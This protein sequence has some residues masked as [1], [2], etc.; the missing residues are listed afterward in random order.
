MQ[1]NMPQISNHN[2]E[3]TD[4]DIK[5]AE[6]ILLKESHFF[7]DE[8]KD[9]IKNLDTID[10]QAVPWSWKT[11]ALLAKLL[12]L[13]RK[14][15][16]SDWSGILVLSHTNTAVDEIKER[17][18]KYAPKLFE[19]P[20]F[21]W[22]IQEFVN[23]FLAKPYFS[24]K[25]KKK[26]EFIDTE[27]YNN[28]IDKEIWFSIRWFTKQQKKNA[29]YFLNWMN[30]LYSINFWI[31]N[32]KIILIDNKN[33]EE[34]VIKK[35]RSDS[36]SVAEKKKVYE[37]ILKFKIKLLEYWYTNFDDAYFLWERYISK[38]P[39]IKK[40]LQKRF[41]Y[42]FVD[43]MQ[44][45][46]KH[47][48]D[49]LED[50]F[51][52][53]WNSESF[54]QRIWDENQAIYDWIVKIQS[55]WKWRDEITWNSNN[56]LKILW[57]HRF[58]QKIANVVK[59]FWL[60]NNDL[61]W[62]RQILNDNW[63]D[64]SKKPILI[65]YDDR[66]L[67]N[68]DSEKKDNLILKEFANI[69]DECKNDWYFKW[70]EK[71]VSK[72]IIWNAKPQEDRSW[73]NKFEL[74]KCRAKHYFFDYSVEWNKSK[75]KTWFKSDKDY[76]H[77][78]D[79]EK[80]PLKSKYNN[81]INLFLNILRNNDVKNENDK[82]F[83]KTSLLK[84]LKEKDEKKYIEFKTKLFEWSNELNN[85]NIDEIAEKLD[86]YFPEIVEIL[87]WTINI[88]FQIK[89]S[90]PTEWLNFSNEEE[91]KKLNTYINE[92]W[93]EIKIWTVHSVK[94]E[95]HTCSL[96]LESS[97][98]WYE[99]KEKI[100]FKSYRWESFWW[101]LSHWKQAMKMLYVWLSRPTHLLCYAIHKDRYNELIS[102][103]WNKEKLEELWEVDENLI[104]S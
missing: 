20:N 87:P 51:Y 58:T 11:T 45:M 100:K 38:F 88:N 54:L 35:P 68:I 60:T 73:N 99:S 12:I 70:V 15:P 31:K 18:W 57:S 67:N 34:L 41:K 62:K 96:Y 27:I 94:W 55:E 40:I 22:T 28:K 97:S 64:I 66:H 92:N 93:I 16:F 19:F 49:I 46:Q 102:W 7:D 43:E 76:L 1:L 104:N 69:I 10:L 101:T 9:F 86:N 39:K 6:S 23:K 56:K 3:I 85:S 103:N 4:E 44:D 84:Y 74:D 65:V 63:E 75:N 59:C 48:V 95:T 78:Y 77:Y 25:F 29:I 98:N 89:Q 37:Y 13:E 26:L 80:N 2:I 8:R 33:Y 5:Y 50:I 91:N 90:S 72:A 82:Y 17:I 14:M 83:N 71:I 53:D 21:I 32:W 42:V 36:W 81:I 61:V 79:K 24:S 30:K 47:Q 52:D